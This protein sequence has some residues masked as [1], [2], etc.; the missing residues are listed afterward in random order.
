[1]TKA[2]IIKTAFQV[3]G[4]RLYQST[5]LSDIAQA[6]GVSKSALYRH[7]KSKQALLGAMYERFFDEYA[8]FI[9]PQYHTALAQEDTRERFFIM[10]RISLEYYTRNRDAFIFSLIFVYSNQDLEYM[11]RSMHDRGLNMGVFGCGEEGNQFYPSLAQLVIAS[12]NFFVAYFHK[13]DHPGEEAPSDEQ[14]SRFIAQVEAK[15]LFGLGL[16]HKTIEE[17]DFEALERR[18]HAGVCGFHRDSAAQELQSQDRNHKKHKRNEDGCLLKAIAAVVAEAGPWN[19]SMDMAARRA[20]LSKSGLYSHFKNKQDMI[21]HVF[22]K[23]FKRILRYAQG[24]LTLSTVPEEQLYLVILSIVDC[25]RSHPEIL[26]AIDWLRTRR[27]SIDSKPPEVLQIFSAIPLKPEG[28]ITEQ[29]GHLI[30]FL[31][32]NTLMRCPPGMARSELPN[33]SNRILYRLIALGLSPP[34]PPPNIH[35]K[36]SPDQGMVLHASNSVYSTIE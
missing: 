2:D 30:L 1:M 22:V 32:I 27:L 15:L 14:V 28:L 9:K 4:R 17:M 8:A 16:S 29:I 34:P 33:G 21:R 10:L 18:F 31:I 6:L 19:V 3:W 20:G 35:E 24:G 7:F 23:E 11:V 13:Y 25:L 36:A 5:S 12:I 26:E